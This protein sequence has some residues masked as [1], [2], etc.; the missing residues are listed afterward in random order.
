MADVIPKVL[1]S[2]SVEGVEVAREIQTELYHDADCT[3]WYQ[4][5]FGPTEYPLEGLVKALDTHEFGSF[6]L[7]PDDLVVKLERDERRRSARDNVIAELFLFIGR[8]GRSRTFLIAPEK[9]SPHLPTDLAGIA[10]LKYRWDKEAGQDLQ[11]AIGAAVHQI[12]KALRERFVPRG[13]KPSH[14]AAPA[15]AAAPSPAVPPADDQNLLRYL[16][17][18][19]GMVSMGAAGLEITHANPETTTFWQQNVLEMLV[20][21]FRSRREDVTATWLRP[22][23]NPDQLVFF[24]GAG[25]H[26]G[27]DHYKYRR[28][29]GMAGKVWARG[30]AAYSSSAKRHE[31]WVVRKDCDNSTYICA[32]VGEPGSEGGVLAVGSDSGFELEN[33][34]FEIVKTFAKIL[35]LS[36]GR[37]PALRTVG[38][39]KKKSGY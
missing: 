5:V 10:P 17:D 19:I 33:I 27:A 36:V 13:G 24:E 20:R 11:Q 37:K 1:I 26:H 25:P 35:S 31:W 16:E 2:S 12:R 39:Q 28:E 22:R 23:E 9:D 15:A 21:L 29:E 14:A 38:A 18:I 6:V 30:Q 8:Y 32:P 4:G 3:I 34:D 7:T